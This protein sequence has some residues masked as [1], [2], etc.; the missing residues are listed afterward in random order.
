MVDK[1]WDISQMRQRSFYWDN[2][3]KLKQV[4]ME[5]RVFQGGRFPALQW[6][7][8]LV[9]PIWLGGENKIPYLIIDYSSLLACLRACVKT[10]LICFW[11]G[12]TSLKRKQ[13][14][15]HAC[16]IWSANSS[17]HVLLKYIQNDLKL[18]PVAT[19]F[20]WSRKASTL[21]KIRTNAINS[22]LEHNF[23]ANM[24]F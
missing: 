17:E 15:L 11:R 20:V 12:F 7:G 3:V 18:G 6:S 10:R 13:W 1:I 14:S 22:N 4:P 2:P 21:A 8:Y 5:P 9:P 19:F 16:Q 24:R 23:H